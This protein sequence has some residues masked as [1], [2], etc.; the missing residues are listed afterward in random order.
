MAKDNDEL[1]ARIASGGD[2]TPDDYKSSTKSDA[3]VLL[4]EGTTYELGSKDKDKK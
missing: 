4:T 3:T 2:L 1:L